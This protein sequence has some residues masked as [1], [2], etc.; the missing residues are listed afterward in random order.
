MTA[1]ERTVAAH[2][3]SRIGIPSSREASDAAAKKVA[4]SASPLWPLASFVA[5]NPFLEKVGV[6]FVEASFQLRTRR[7]A[8]TTMP[9]SFYR[10]AVA[11]GALVS[12]RLAKATAALDAAD[13]PNDSRGPLVPTVVS[14]VSRLANLDWERISTERI[15]TWAAAYFDHGQASLESPFRGLRPY[16]AWLAEATIDVSVDVLGAKGFRR[17]LGNLPSDPLELVHRAVT[18]LGVPES[19]LE[20]YLEAVL[21]SVSGWASYARY[22]DWQEGNRSEGTRN[23]LEV[24][25]IR[26]AWEVALYEA[27]A[28]R[29]SARSWATA[30]GARALAQHGPLEDSLRMEALVHEAYEEAIHAKTRI[31]L[32]TTT[33]AR[34]E[35]RASAQLVFCIDV[36]SEV[37]RRALERTS[38]SIETLGF[39][40]FFGLSLDHVEGHGAEGTSLCPVLLRPSLVLREPEK[41]SAV[42]PRARAWNSF[43]RSAVSCFSYVSTAGLSY[44]VHLVTESLGIHTKHDSGPTKPFASRVVLG[45][46]QHG[47]L[48]TEARADLAEKML[49]AMSLTK[50]FAPLVVLVG[51]GSTSANNAHAASLDCGACGG[52]SGRTNA[53]AAGMVL[54]DPAIRAILA[55][56]GIAIPDDTVFLAGLHDTTTDV[57]SLFDVDHLAPAHASRVT[58][59][60]RC[61]AEAGRAARTERAAKL[62]LPHGVDHGVALTARSRD[63]SNVRP[64]WGLA[65]CVAFVVSGRGTTRGKELLGTTFLHTYEWKDDPSFATLELILTAPMVVASWINLQ[66]FASVVEPTAY[67]SGNKVLHNVVGKLGVLE[68]QSGDLRTGLPLQSVH[69]GTQFVHTPAK[70][71]VYI[72]AP[73][74]AIEA[75]LAA[76]SDVRALFDH[77]WLTLF[78][79]DDAMRVSHR[80]VSLG[81]W[82]SL[83]SDRVG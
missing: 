1:I 56:R 29:G 80:Y 11:S 23:V 55:T 24:L 20:E 25:A 46:P 82:E 6:P 32:E 39:A 40:G 59:L 75:V 8:R 12:E 52:N 65:G 79:L 67:G 13:A 66:Y 22:L 54:G 77:R 38:D 18:L 14:V 5:V 70:L 33:L 4:L 36:R 83:P 9:R 19:G 71:A 76:H 81:A 47:E 60:T 51:H 63:W 3:F 68:G 72:Q 53:E 35:A 57:V 15:S 2:A 43:K 62:D 28:E 17:T 58:E 31:A 78:V 64:E 61:L 26:C 37:F 41:E 34:N 73:M 21:S 7:G 74:S 27:Y 42:S 30:M 16:A 48:S 45:A 49:R 44:A 69:D 10:E 50:D